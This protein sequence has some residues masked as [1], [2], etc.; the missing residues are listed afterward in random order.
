MRI[1]IADDDKISRTLLQKQLEKLGYHVTAAQ[2]GEEAWEQA[3]NNDFSMIISDW[4]MPGLNGIEFVKKLRRKRRGDYVY[5]ILLTA[6]QTT[7]DLI[8]GLESGADDFI[9]KP[10]HKEELRVRV[11]SGERI[12]NLER[13]LKTQNT[14]LTSLNQEMLKDL[15]SAARIQQSL[16]PRQLPRSEHFSFSFT[17]MPSE[18]LGGDTLNILQIDEHRIAMYLV[19]VSG[20]GVSAAMLAF[21]LS[22][23]LSLDENHSVLFRSGNNGDAAD[24]R[25]RS[26]REVIRVLN[27]SF[28]VEEI[29]NQYFT[30]VYGIY[31][32]RDSSFRF[33]SAG[34]PGIL[35]ITDTNHPELYHAS[36]LAIGFCR[37]CVYEETVLEMKPGARL[38]LYSDGINEAAGATREYFGHQRVLSVLCAHKDDDITRATKNLIETA[39]NWQKRHRFNDDISVIAMEILS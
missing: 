38:Y 4:M 39:Q 29:E 37:D 36:G 17:Y 33:V 34:H 14:R 20:H 13:S 32:L 3:H 19:D 24:D 11:M 9:R 7:E 6:K 2:D 16:L 15:R 5:F 22:R 1:L 28:A 30:I 21:S 27:Q 25:I 8:E 23:M 31:D 35:H 12:V 26:P 18:E 10:F